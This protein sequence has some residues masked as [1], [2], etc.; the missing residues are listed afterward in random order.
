VSTIIRWYRAHNS[1]T[2]SPNI[3]DNPHFKHTIQFVVHGFQQNIGKCTNLLLFITTPIMTVPYRVR[4]VWR[5]YN[6]RD[7]YIKVTLS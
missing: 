6:V 4:S 1:I 3:S 2:Q 7:C 5:H